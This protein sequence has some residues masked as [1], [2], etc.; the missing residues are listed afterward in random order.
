[1][2]HFSRPGEAI[3]TRIFSQAAA[4]ARIAGKG[5]IFEAAASGDLAF[6]ADHLT[7]DPKR[8]RATNDL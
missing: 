2:R 5:D 8:A 1:M 4:K 7:V 6:L 3:H